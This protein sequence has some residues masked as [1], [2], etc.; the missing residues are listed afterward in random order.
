MRARKTST[1][2]RKDQIAQAALDLLADRGLGELSVAVLA[3]RVGLVPSAIYRHFRSKEEVLDS[4]VD[5]IGNRLL[6]NVQAVLGQKT[7]DLNRLR[8][9]LV[10]HVELIQTNRGIPRIVFSEDFYRHRPQR[11]LQLYKAIQ[12]YLKAVAEIVRS[13]QEKGLIRRELDSD[14]VAVMFLGLV[15]PAGIL[16]HM[17]NGKFNPKAHAAKAWRIFV[18]AIRSN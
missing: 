7:N 9:L 11:R 1:K 3:R 2:I 4:I 13:G 16:W 17:S 8:H 5:L 6:N 15:Q 18:R 12:K 14:T 10:R